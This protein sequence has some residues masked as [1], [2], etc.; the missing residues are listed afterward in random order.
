MIEKSLVKQHYLKKKK[1][2]RNL[3]IEDIIEADYNH[4]KRVCKDFEIKS[5]G[6]YHNLYLRSDVLLLA[7]VFE[8]FCKICLEIYELD[9]VKFISAPRLAWQAV[10]KKTEV[11]LDLL[12]DIDRLLMVEK[13]IR[14]GICNTIHWYEKSNN[15]YMKD[16]DNNK[17]SLYLNY[18]DVNNLYGWATSQKLPTFNFKW[19]R[20]TSQFY[21]D[22]IK[23]YDEKSK[24][25]FLEA[26]VQ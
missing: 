6:E 3:T 26:D 10:L 19:V 17:E 16:Y 24:G 7:N 2:Y 1:N 14:G 18:W 22:F 5:L 13:G 21:E 9:P 20:D 23:N 12:A 8:N 15:K 25:C 4:G 11:E